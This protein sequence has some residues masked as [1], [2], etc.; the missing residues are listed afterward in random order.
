MG[1]VTEP[2]PTVLATE[3]PEAMPSRAEATTATLAGPPAKRPTA[4]LARSMNRS[5]APL[6]SKNAPKR[7]NTAINLAQTLMGVDKMPS[8]E[9]T[10]VFMRLRSRAAKATC[11]D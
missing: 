3:E 9:K 7:M 6:R 4:T 2:E 1:M 11:P 5:A 10:M 8:V